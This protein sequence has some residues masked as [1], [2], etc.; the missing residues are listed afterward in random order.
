[1]FFT[2]CGR[3]GIDPLDHSGNTHT[4]RTGNSAI[5]CL[6]VARCL[7]THWTT[8]V[9]WMEGVS[10]HALLTASKSRTAGNRKTCTP[11]ALKQLPGQAWQDLR[12]AYQGL[13]R[14]LDVPESPPL[15]EW[16]APVT[17]PAHTDLGHGRP[18]WGAMG[19]APAPLPEP[20]PDTDPIPPCPL[21]AAYGRGF[22][23]SVLN[24][25][26]ER[27]RKSGPAAQSLETKLR[28]AHSR[29]G[30][31]RPSPALQAWPREH[32]WLSED[33]GG[34][35]I[36]GAG[37]ISTWYVAYRTQEAA[38]RRAQLPRRLLGPD[39]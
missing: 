8:K 34:A 39:G 7:G 29:G 2:L 27:W 24:T 38:R 6:A 32:G 13:E 5:D 16:R 37:D 35:A 33:Q 30:A 3:W 15:P 36:I 4:W 10:D 25:L 12:R 17:R 18:A 19:E 21:V 23:E 9:H 26:W 14:L 31:H 11:G 1:M 20:P 22:L 28:S